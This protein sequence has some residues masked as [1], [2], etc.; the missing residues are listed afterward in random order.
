MREARCAF[1]L[2]FT[3]CLTAGVTVTTLKVGQRHTHVHWA[4]LV[5]VLLIEEFEVLVSKARGASG[6]CEL[7]GFAIVYTLFAFV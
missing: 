6:V 1:I 7:A 4:L 5:A 2:K 3:A